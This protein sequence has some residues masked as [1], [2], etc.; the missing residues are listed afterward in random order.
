MMERLSPAEIPPFELAPEPRK[1]IWI[2]PGR[3]AKAD[4]LTIETLESSNLHT[5]LAALR[6]RVAGRPVSCA[7]SARRKLD[8]I[9]EILKK[10][11][12]G[13]AVWGGDARSPCRSKCCMA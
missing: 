6:A 3:G 1:L 9:A 8:E 13:V 4:G 12:F 2:A 10:A 7:K 5:T 11:R